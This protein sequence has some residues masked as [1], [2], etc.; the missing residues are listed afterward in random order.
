MCHAVEEGFL[1]RHPHHDVLMTQFCVQSSVHHIA[2]SDPSNMDGQ[3]PTR[4]C[5]FA[6]LKMSG[7]CS[8][9]DADREC[10]LFRDEAAKP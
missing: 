10:R 9:H 6:A 7:G 4:R 2:R 8:V 5:T 1:W 3:M